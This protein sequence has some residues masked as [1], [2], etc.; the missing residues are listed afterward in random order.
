MKIDWKRKLT[1]RKFW[2]A[3]CGFVSMWVMALWK[4]ASKAQT[5]TGMIM[6]AGS[7]IAYII[8]EGLADSKPD[9]TP[10]EFAV[11]KA[12]TG[13]L[14]AD[15]TKNDAICKKGYKVVVAGEDADA[16]DADEVCEECMIHYDDDNEWKE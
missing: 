2:A 4:D 6:A 9:E 7:L 10:S 5:V 8:G 14:I 3:V 13:E 16:E 15:N 11:V 12:G 1:S